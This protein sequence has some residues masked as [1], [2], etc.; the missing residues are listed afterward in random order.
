MVVRKWENREPKTG[1]T[2]YLTTGE[3]SNP[4]CIF[5]TYDWRRVIENGIFKEGKHPWH[6]VRLGKRTEAAVVV[7]CFFTLLVMARCTAFRLWQAHSAIPPTS[8]TEVLAP[9]SSALLAG[10][11]TARGRQRLREADR[12]K[13]IVFIGHACGI[14]HLAEF[15]VLTHIPIRILPASLGSPQAVLQR[16]GISP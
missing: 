6:R 8:S 11:G 5:D 9:L 2:V 1:G 12:D 14:F 7:H 13:I 3:V 16:F 10:E 4:F 15:A